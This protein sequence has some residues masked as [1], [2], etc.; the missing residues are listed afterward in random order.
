[1]HG[2]MERFEPTSINAVAAHAL[3]DETGRLA[4]HLSAEE[5]LARQIMATVERKILGGRLST[6]AMTPSVALYP[7]GEHRDRC[8]WFPLDA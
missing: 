5:G 1:M 4:R 2:P 3:R 8:E 6:P 7:R